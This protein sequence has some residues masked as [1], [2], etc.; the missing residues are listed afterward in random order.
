MFIHILPLRYL[1][2]KIFNHHQD[3]IAM[4]VEENVSRT[5]ARCATSGSSATPRSS[6]SCPLAPAFAL[7]PGQG[8][9][10]LDYSN[11]SHIK[12]YY[13]AVTPLKHEFDGKP[14]NLRIFMKIVANQAKSF[15]WA[16]ILN[17]ND[18]H[19][20]TRSLP[21]DYG[22]LMTAEVKLHARNQWTNQHTRDA[23]NAEMLYHF[24]F[25][26]LDESFKATILLK[27]HNYQVT[28]GTYTTEDGSCLLKQ[29]IV[30]TFI[31][32]R[33][34]ASQIQESLVDMAQ[35]LETQKGNI[36]NSTSA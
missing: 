26:S 27:N 8:N 13:K 24:L 15:G 33:T 4:K 29:T 31:D 36:T 7:G 12:T 22:Q 16:N 19:G 14:S 10:L 23:Q 35:Q 3:K 21:N 34:M 25:E 18:S 20:N 17:S 9:A 2:I 32:T 5:R 28:V 1:A 11:A 30:R 6:S